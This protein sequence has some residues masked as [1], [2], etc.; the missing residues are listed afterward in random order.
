MVSVATAER[1]RDKEGIRHR[2]I[3]CVPVI[4]SRVLRMEQSKRLWIALGMLAV[5]AILAWEIMSDES[6]AIAGGQISY[7]G[8]TLVILG[9]FAARTVLHWRA[10]KIRTENEQQD[11]SG[12][13]RE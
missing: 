10:S 1:R 13:T 5:L 9:I 2:F 8:F 12:M 11:L 6:I 4:S 7:R 3:F